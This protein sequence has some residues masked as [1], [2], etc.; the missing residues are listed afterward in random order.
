[1]A[2]QWPVEASPVV[3]E[4]QDGSGNHILVLNRGG[5]LLLWSADGKAL[6]TG[7]DGLV[8]QLPPGRWTTAPIRV[9]SP[10]I[11]FI[12]ASVEGEVL[13][14]GSQF[15]PR[16]K[17]QLPGET[18]WGQAVPAKVNTSSG[19]N[20]VF[21]DLSGTVSCFNADGRVLWT[22]KLPAGCMAAPETMVGNR[23]EDDLLVPAGTALF[24]LDSSGHLL[25]QRDLADPASPRGNPGQEVVT[26]PLV[27]STRERDFV[28]CGT[29]SGKVAALTRK[30]KILWTR[31][32]GDSLGHSLSLLPRPGSD[33]LILCAGLWGNL[34]ALELNGHIAWSHLFRA[35][36]RAAPVAVDIEG[37]GH[38]QALL[39]TF[40]QHVYQ[41][42]AK[43][44]LTDDIRLSGILPASLTPLPNSDSKTPDLLAT[45]TTLLSYRLRPGPPKSPY[46]ATAA[47]RDV[48]VAL[49]SIEASSNVPGTNSETPGL[50]ISNPAGALLRI[51]LRVTDSHGWSRWIGRMSSRSTMEIPL[52][53]ISRQGDWACHAEVCDAAGTVLQAKDWNLPLKVKARPMSPSNTFNVWATLPYGAFDE[54]CLTPG[55]RSRVVLSTN[56]IAIETLYLDEIDQG[57]FIVASGCEQ[58]ATMRIDIK[59]LA[60]SDGTPFGGKIVL[61]EVICTGS[62]N[63]ERVPDALPALNE[64]GLLTV[65]GRRAAKIWIS[66]DTHGAQ[67]GNYSG[68]VT[69]SSLDGSAEKFE[70]P[71]QLEILDLRLPPEF[72]LKL[73]T[74]DYIPNR[75]F[76]SNSTEVLNDMS[77]HGVN[78]FPRSTLPSARRDTAGSL[79]V[80]WSVLDAELSRL[81]GRGKILFH[82]NHPAI[83]FANATTADQKHAAELEYIR[84]LR[85]HL[86]ANGRGYADYA[87][88]L[89]DE[90]GLDYGTNVPVLLDAGHLF[91]EAD[92]RLLT[93]TDPVPG[94]SWR[95]FERIEPLV[96]VWAPNMRLVSGLLSGDPRI[97]RIIT[98][99]NVW[100]YECVSQVKSLS[101]LCYNRANAWR[102]KS[103]GLSGI[104]FWTHST[105]EADLWLPGKT[106]NDEYAL[107]YPGALPVPSVRWEAVRDGLEDIAAISL[108]EEQIRRH[109]RS[110]TAAETVRLAEQALNMA[111]SDVM[112]LSDEAFIESRDFLRAGDRVLSHTWTDAELFGKH[113]ARI[114]L[115]TRK[116]AAEKTP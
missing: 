108:L 42:D 106:E 55:T 83:E 87:F 111:L 109:Q 50:V 56:G 84:A 52:P 61:R 37:D 57:A 74:W 90:P 114:A 76:P 32:L 99:K 70:L 85:D 63:G 19:T 62:V 75:W 116:L 86:Q 96:D 110:G 41:F 54:T 10:Q 27:L 95:D 24:C 36:V 17:Y 5:Q 64:A 39:P 21:A 94:L 59:R 30:G 105:T 45:T 49:V 107:V 53:E 66:V 26:R 58:S 47:P 100:S 40:H 43:G 71:L 48:S 77:R 78:L 2:G 73:C 13:G 28:C 79:S 4:A 103:F 91:R 9:I 115:L 104:G 23:G 68:Q 101:P 69:I 112:E 16:W 18:V 113:R 81:N 14:L 12:L 3:L 51:N 31:Q 93:Y 92:P 33:P 11:Q 72:P 60:R 29:A 67:P 6:G 98:N 35:K 82:L 8:E 20:F 46:A 22:N 1:M 44:K 38:F 88:Y 80:D 97:C 7:Q 102:A 65:P 15:R 34:H 25:W 89:L